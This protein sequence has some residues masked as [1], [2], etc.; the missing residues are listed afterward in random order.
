[1]T[2]AANASR[3]FPEKSS[4]PRKSRVLLEVDGGE[5]PRHESQKER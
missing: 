3:D 1:M 4:I 2:T 5:K